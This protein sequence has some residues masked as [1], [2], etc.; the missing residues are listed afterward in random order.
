MWES[1]FVQDQILALAD[2]RCDL[3]YFLFKA[4][5]G[6]ACA[7]TP[8]LRAMWMSTTHMATGRRAPWPAESSQV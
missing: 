1:P 3:R 2:R 8:E 7:V 6:S 5:H 4:G